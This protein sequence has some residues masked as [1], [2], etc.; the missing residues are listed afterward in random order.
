M[1][2]IRIIEILSLF[3]AKVGVQVD[4]F[5]FQIFNILKLKNKYRC[6]SKFSSYNY[7]TIEIQIKYFF[8]N[9]ATLIIQYS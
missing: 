1:F 5:G 4:D 7:S 8:I 2:I 6:R 9:L 3:Y